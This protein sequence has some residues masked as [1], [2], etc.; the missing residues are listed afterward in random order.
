MS[1]SLFTALTALQANQDWIDVVGNNLANAN[2]R[3]FKSASVTFSDLFSQ[4]LRAATGPNGSLGGRNPVQ[5]GSG[6]RVGTIARNFAQ[7]T[8][9]ETGRTFDLGI[10]GRG[11]FALLGAQGQVY[12]RV[13]SF[14]LDAERNLV[15]LRTGYSVL[16]ASGDAIQLD[17]DSLFPPKATETVGLSGNLPKEVTGPLAEVL[18]GAEGLTH[19]FPA[20]LT[21]DQA[22]PF[23]IP[24]G[25]SRTMSVTISGGAPQQ[26]TIAGTGSPITAATIAAAIDA[27]D[28][29]SATVDSN[30]FVQ[31][32]TDRV[33]EDVSI[34]VTPGPAGSDLAGMLG[35]STALVS[36]SES[37]LS[38][39]TTLNDLPANVTDY[40]TGDVIEIS[41]VDTDGTPVN[42]SFVYGVDGTTVDEFV[43]FIDGLYA[44]ARVSLDAEGR[45]VVEAQTPGEAGLL[46]SISDGAGQAGSTQWSTYA[47]N[48]STEG[49]GPDTVVASTEVFDSAGVGHQ[50]TFTLERQIDGSWTLTPSLAPEEGTVLSPPIT[51]LT[52][53]DDGTPVGLG[54][55]AKT[56]TVQL[57]GQSQAQELT[58]DLGSDGTLDGLTQL[59]G[60]ASVWVSSQDGYSTGALS[61]LGVEND[62]TISGFYTN[63]QSRSLGEIGLAVFA[64]PEGLKEIGDNLWAETPN[65]GDLAFGAAGSGSSGEIVGGALE[66]SNV[67]T[68]TQFVHLI[69]A[70]RGY[71]A[72]A[73]VITLQDE[74]LAETV[75]LI[76]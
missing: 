71:Q 5:I 17:V 8:L 49:S 65:S 38:P 3:G 1:G 6:V 24:A 27:L 55:I 2:T 50:M 16:S 36:G 23:T 69:E 44:D 51:G 57:A 70:Q 72:S 37:P 48:V 60:E 34:K 32:S 75:N 15:D 58:L 54:S 31:L 12:T 74:M 68:A 56:V 19:G 7:G 13:G 52:F 26:V 25:E 35:L 61:S 9:T 41:G 39:T 64:N 45:L 11:F 22:G 47:L 67:D 59:G 29:V 40:Q 20:V 18:T 14:G 76:R 53:G 10:N 63:G 66:N 21:G 42:A 43:S 4:N 33:G 46:L 62:G 28:D 30:G 73:R